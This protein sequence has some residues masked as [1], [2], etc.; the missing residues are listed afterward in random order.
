VKRPLT[1]EMA[2]RQGLTPACV[3][4]PH[5]GTAWRHLTPG[6]DW[7]HL[8][9]AW[10]HLTPTARRHLIPELRASRPPHPL[11]CVASP[12][13]G[14][15]LA[16]PHPGTAWRRLTPDRI[17]SSPGLHGVK[18]TSPP[19][20]RGVTSPWTVWRQGH[21]TPWTAW[22]RLTRNCVASRAPHPGPAE[23]QGRPMGLGQGAA[24]LI[25]P[26]FEWAAVIRPRRRLYLIRTVPRGWA[27]SVPS[28]G[29]N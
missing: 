15:W 23:D 26:G 28:P 24:P 14:N 10:R 2:W 27:N 12:H 22:R 17:A 29:L 16:P 25:P 6:T 4:S 20:L 19:G 5:A 3:A 9:T 18:G 7:R 11:D 1:R 8:R 21:L 13:P